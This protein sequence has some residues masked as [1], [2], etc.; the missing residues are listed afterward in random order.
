M[1]KEI[2]TPMEKVL[3]KSALLAQALEDKKKQ[4]DAA[5]LDLMLCEM[6][7]KQGLIDGLPAEAWLL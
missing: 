4:V 1:E 2:Y 5:K 7:E 6:E 3:L